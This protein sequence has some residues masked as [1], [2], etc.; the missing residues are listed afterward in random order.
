LTG[1]RYRSRSNWPPKAPRPS[2]LCRM[3]AQSGFDL[4]QR[5]RPRNKARCWRCGRAATG[6]R[7]NL[8]EGPKI[9]NK[10]EKDEP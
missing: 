8:C 6:F 5:H 4:Y 10:I 1:Q 2:A 9:E 3:A 7:T